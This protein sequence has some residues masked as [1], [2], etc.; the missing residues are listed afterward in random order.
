MNQERIL[1]NTQCAW[2]C[3]DAQDTKRSTI[4]R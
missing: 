2:T 3:D 1:Y 4:T